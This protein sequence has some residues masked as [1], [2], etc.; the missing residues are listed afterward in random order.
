MTG[1]REWNWAGEP[2]PGPRPISNAIPFCEGCLGRSKTKW[3]MR[4]TTRL[5][6][7]VTSRAVKSC[8]VDPRTNRTGI[9]RPR[10]WA[11]IKE[12]RHKAGDGTHSGAV[13]NRTNHGVPLSW[14]RRVQGDD[15]LRRN[16]PL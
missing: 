5:R 6:E 9:C 16:K 8:R 11:R 7:S 12:H 1:E 14:S 2:G 13:A 3:L 4:S 15:V 10:R